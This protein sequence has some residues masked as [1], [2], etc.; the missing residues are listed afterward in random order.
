MG[1]EDNSVALHAL[2]IDC[3]LLCMSTHATPQKSPYDG[4]G[5]PS[6]NFLGSLAIE[7]LLCILGFSA[8]PMKQNCGGIKISSNKKHA[9]FFK[10]KTPRPIVTPVRKTE[11]KHQDHVSCLAHHASSVSQC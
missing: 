5:G 11:I 10:M 2:H 6:A 7:F 1:N 8:I 9:T 3:L 4:G